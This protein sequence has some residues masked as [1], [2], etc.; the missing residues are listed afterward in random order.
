MNPL[1]RRNVSKGGAT[2]SWAKIYLHIPEI[3]I[4]NNRKVVKIE[5]N[6][7]KVIFFAEAFLE[8]EPAVP[9]RKK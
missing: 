8:R 5:Y 3:F 4:W 2:R 6:I 7:N 1:S 9:Y